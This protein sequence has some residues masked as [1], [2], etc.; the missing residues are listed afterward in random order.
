MVTEFENIID[1]IQSAVFEL[2]SLD[3]SCKR[4]KL[5]K[6]IF[7]VTIRFKGKG[8][9]ACTLKFIERTTLRSLR[10]AHKTQPSLREG[11]HHAGRESPAHELL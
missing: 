10:R 5:P 11:S 2:L 8:I 9:S 7:E 6:Q 3:Q 4:V 1:H